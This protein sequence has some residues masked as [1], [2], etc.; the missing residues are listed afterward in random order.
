LDDRALSDAL[1]TC[2][3]AAGR[4]TARECRD[5]AIAQVARTR[6]EL[7]RHLAEATA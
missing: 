6:D 3:G 7:I 2:L 4:Q 5:Y 1:D